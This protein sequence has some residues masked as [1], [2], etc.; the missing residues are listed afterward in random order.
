MRLIPQSLLWRTFLLIAT[1]I[2]LAVAAWVAIFR[3]AELEPRARQLA[4]MI[5]S[6]VNLTRVALVTA[7]PESRRILLTELSA[8]EKVLVYPTEHTDRVAPLPDDPLAKLIDSLLREQ[9]GPE[10]RFSLA[11]ND[12]PGLFIRFNIFPGEYGDFWLVLPRERIERD[13][14]LRWIGW[15]FLVLLLAILGAWLIF[16]RISQP[17]RALQNAARKVGAGETP[18]ELPER[19]PTEIVALTRTFNRMG[20]SLQRLEDDRRLLLAGISHD[21]RTPLTRLRMETEMS[22]ADAT[23]RA[24]MEADI[25]EMDRTIGQFLDF[26]RTREELD[27]L[28][29]PLDLPALLDDIGSRYGARLKRT[30]SVDFPVYVRVTTDS[31]RRAIINLI[32]NALRHGGGTPVE[33]SL[34]RE[35]GQVLILV[36]DRGPGIPSD[37][38]ERM[39]LPF[40]R[41]EVARTGA[42]GAGLGLAIVDRIIRSQGGNFNLLS[43]PDGGLIARISLPEFI[44]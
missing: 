6:V 38:V 40:T 3:E 8:S 23:S 44:S 2:L 37:E 22:V 15:G 1:L 20:A 19:G 30:A 9:L 14:P 39:K 24:E 21:L 13:L 34:V 25:A 4:Q 7:R 16:F 12:K 17:L 32:E 10:T 29:Q 43:R 27:A 5:S 35:E 42:S 28:R 18:P 36:M 41:G 26:A 11:L 31:L 33:L